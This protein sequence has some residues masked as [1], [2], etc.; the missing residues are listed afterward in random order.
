[1]LFLGIDDMHYGIMHLFLDFYIT[2]KLMAN[3]PLKII[4]LSFPAIWQSIQSHNV[5]L[6]PIVTYKLQSRP[7][8]SKCENTVS[9]EYVTAESL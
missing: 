4:Y 6:V 5:Y 7:V 9:H 1:M 3:F 2:Y 8:G